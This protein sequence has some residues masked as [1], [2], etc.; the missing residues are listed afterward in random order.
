MLKLDTWI[1][2][3]LSYLKQV[4]KISSGT[5]V[6]MRCTFRNVSRYI[7]DHFP[8]KKLWKL[9][10]EEFLQWVENEREKNRSTGTIAKDISHIRGLLE[11]SW[12]SGRTSRNVLDGFNLQDKKEPKIPPRALSMDEVEVLIKPIVLHF[13]NGLRSSY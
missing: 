3:Y 10:L 11:Y 7:K 9:E 8:E 6:D 1:E 12:R 2:G 5:I 4:R 13:F